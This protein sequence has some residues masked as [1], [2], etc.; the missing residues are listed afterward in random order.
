M[1]RCETMSKCAITEQNDDF[2]TFRAQV[3]GWAYRLL[4]NMHDSQD[5]AQEVFLRWNRQ[6]KVG[7]PEQP[8]GWLRRVTLNCAIDVCRKAQVAEPAGPPHWN[9][10]TADVPL[11][12]GVHLDLP[13]LRLDLAAALQELTDA[14]RSVIVAKVFEELTFA[15]I[16]AELGLATS[17]VKTHYLRAVRSLSRILRPRWA[18]PEQVRHLG[19]PT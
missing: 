7:C 6:L 18:E 4:G 16:A 14:Q 8:R 12:A 10:P 19:A 17:T 5:V 9:R 3:Y 2:E 15:E 11:V 13:R 1:K